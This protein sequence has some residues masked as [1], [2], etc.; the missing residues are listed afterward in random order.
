LNNALGESDPAGELLVG[1]SYFLGNPCIQDLDRLKQQLRRK[2]E[3]QVQPLLKEYAQVMP[4][5]REA[6]FTRE[7]RGLLGIEN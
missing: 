5:E 3:C 6:D 7:F 4:F 2:W 1:H